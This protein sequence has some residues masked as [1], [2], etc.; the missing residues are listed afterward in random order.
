MNDALHL[1]VV[2][3]CPDE[4]TKEAIAAA[5]RQMDAAGRAGGFDDE[6]SALVAAYA[7]SAGRLA[8]YDAL[9]KG[10]PTL[11]DLMHRGV[12]EFFHDEPWAQHTGH[13]CTDCLTVATLTADLAAAYYVGP[14][15]AVALAELNAGDPDVLADDEPDDDE[16]EN[17]APAGPIVL[18][19]TITERL[20]RDDGPTGDDDPGF[21]YPPGMSP[22][23]REIE[24]L[25]ARAEQGY[26]RTQLLPHVPDRALH[27]SVPGEWRES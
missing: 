7:Y 15:N 26:D 19:D 1:A 8:R 20:P 6:V 24:R 12:H 13:D 25:S 22:E 21:E 9:V 16:W 2:D 27:T 14:Y 10:Q 4:V 5:H 11:I 17:D 23:D 3:G 18:P